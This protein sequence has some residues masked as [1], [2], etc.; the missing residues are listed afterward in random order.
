MRANSK[1]F[2]EIELQRKRV[3]AAKSLLREAREQAHSAKVRRKLAK[4]LAKR[5]VEGAKQAKERLVQAKEDLARAQAMVSNDQNGRAARRK[6]TEPPPVAR[7]PS[8]PAHKRPGMRRKLREPAGITAPA[9]AVS[10]FTS[11]FVDDSASG[12]TP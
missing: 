3:A 11:D 5:A 2:V 6:T 12:S 10:P 8:K 1:Q 7:S 9:P 4:L